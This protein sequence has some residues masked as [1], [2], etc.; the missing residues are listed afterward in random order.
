MKY[1][2]A[3][4]LCVGLVVSSSAQSRSYRHVSLGR[5]YRH[6]IRHCHVLHRYHRRS[7]A[8]SALALGDKPPC[9]WK[10]ASMGGPCGCWAEWHFLH[11]ADHVWRGINMW[12]ADDWLR[13]PRAIPAPGTAAVWP[14]RHVAPVIAGPHPDGTVTVKDS[15]ATHRVRMAGLVFVQPPSEHKLGSP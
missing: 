1:V 2:W 5:S 10:A 12:L 14:H 15:W 13:F 8:R 9:F 6:C 7:Y 11:I 4:A 3:L